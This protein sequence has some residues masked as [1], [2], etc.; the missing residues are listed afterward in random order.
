M[1]TAA[2]EWR[3]VVIVAVVGVVAVNRPRVLT[4]SCL[5]TSSATG[6]IFRSATP[7]TQAQPIGCCCEGGRT[8][9][10]EQRGDHWAN[11]YHKNVTVNYKSLKIS[12]LHEVPLAEW[13]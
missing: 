4:A 3:R 11:Q 1:D 10:D 6:R 12:G 5:A 13:F 8:V 9:R 7:A 2:V